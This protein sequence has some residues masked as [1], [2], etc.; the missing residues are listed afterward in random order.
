MM[1]GLHCHSAFI[2]AL[3]DGGFFFELNR[4]VKRDALER[5]V[6]VSSGCSADYFRPQLPEPLALTGA[7]AV[8]G[9]AVPPGVVDGPGFIDDWLLCV[10]FE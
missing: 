5:P 10:A 3:L 9:V 8:P 2:R 6:H 4:H 7:P 1:A